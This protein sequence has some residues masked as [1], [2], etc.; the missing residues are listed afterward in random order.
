[1]R[2]AQV[3]GR[4]GSMKLG[5]GGTGAGILFL[6]ACSARV[7]GTQAARR[8]PPSFDVLQLLPSTV[9]DGEA[10]ANFGVLQSGVATSEESGFDGSA[11][12]GARASLDSSAVRVPVPKT[13]SAANDTL[14]DGVPED[15]ASLSQHFSQSR[16]GEAPHSLAANTG[17]Q[18]LAPQALRGS[19]PSGAALLE[20]RAQLGTRTRIV[21][22]TSKTDPNSGT[23]GVFLAVGLVG[24]LALVFCLWYCSIF[25]R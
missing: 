21:V 13:Q 4:I 9:E 8:T 18:V 17:T 25:V 1:M 14:P 3:K 24:G 19:K 6:L 7:L 23:S 16:V 10:S 5:L 15:V 20:E 2:V 11:S 12:A 22:T